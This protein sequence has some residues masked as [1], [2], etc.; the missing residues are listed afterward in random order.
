MREICTS[1]SVGGEGGNVLPYPAVPRPRFVTAVFGR[2][3]NLPARHYDLCH[4]E[5]AARAAEAMPQT[6]ARSPK[7][8]TV[9]R[10]E[11]SVLRYWTQG[12]SQAP[13]LQRHVQTRRSV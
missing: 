8:A 6:E 7:T 3:G 10:R 12:A 4:E 11:A 2:H 5:L 1:G 9:E 13:G